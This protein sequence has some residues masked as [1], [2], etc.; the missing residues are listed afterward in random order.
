MGF[1]T[2]EIDRKAE[3][4]RQMESERKLQAEKA[5]QA[6]ENRIAAIVQAQ[7]AAGVAGLEEKLVKMVAVQKPVEEPVVAKVPEVIVVPVKKRSF[8]GECARRIGV[9]IRG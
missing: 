1:S 5:R 8:L 4:I 9:L 6:E 3:K 2:E 7:V